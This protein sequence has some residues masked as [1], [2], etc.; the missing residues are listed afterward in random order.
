MTHFQQSFLL[1]YTDFSLDQWL[2]DRGEAA[3]GSLKPLAVAQL[4]DY[5][6][7]SAFYETEQCDRDVFPYRKPDNGWNICTQIKEL[8]QFNND[9]INS[10]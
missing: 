2:A 6:G 7:I 9:A 8:A 5:L 4:E 3:A 1:Y 10:I